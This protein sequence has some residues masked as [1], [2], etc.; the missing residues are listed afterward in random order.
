MDGKL[1]AHTEAN[2]AR[3]GAYGIAQK[4]AAYFQLL[5]LDHM[6][7]MLVKA[8]ES[9]LAMVLKKAVQNLG[10]LQLPSTCTNLRHGSF[11]RTPRHLVVIIRTYLF[12][13]GWAGGVC[14][15][16]Y[17]TLLPTLKGTWG[18]GR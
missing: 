7:V 9:Q 1:P 14:V 18:Q 8:L 16:P 6:H 2:N 13:L 15:H 4:R 17:V 3:G 10:L 12:C 11:K 5:G